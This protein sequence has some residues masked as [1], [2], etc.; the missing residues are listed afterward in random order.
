M[1]MTSFL[2]HCTYIKEFVFHSPFQSSIMELPAPFFIPKRSKLGPPPL[3]PCLRVLKCCAT[4]PQFNFEIFGAPTL[5]RLDITASYNHA[6]WLI[7]C[8]KKLPSRYPGLERLSIG[9]DVKRPVTGKRLLDHQPLYLAFKQSLAE[10]LH[11]PSSSQ[12]RC[13]KTE[14]P[15]NWQDV[16]TLAQLPHFET[17]HAAADFADFKQSPGDLPEGSFASLRHL[18]L[19]LWFLDEAVLRILENIRSPVLESLDFTVWVNRYA[20]DVPGRR[21]AYRLFQLASLE[22]FRDTLRRF[23]LHI[24]DND[25]L[26]RPEDEPPVIYDL[27]TIEILRHVRSL[28]RV[29]IVVPLFRYG[30]MN[31][32]GFRTLAQAWRRLRKLVIYSNCGHSEYTID[33]RTLW[34]FAF[35]PALEELGFNVISWDPDMH[36]DERLEPLKVDG[37][38]VPRSDSVKRLSVPRIVS[39]A[40]EGRAFIREHV[41][42]MFPNASVGGIRV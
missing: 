20:P 39:S 40:K 7:S 10:F 21:L 34:P 23:R 41:Q 17:L 35:S 37:K 33:V 8:L 15:I 25:T 9:T 36:P 1:D 6:G 5:R 19:K 31:L 29:S 4:R 22:R 12:F 32:R 24:V 13:L 30:R 18:Q 27:D 16:R 42:W 28:E 2:R 14:L 11:S 3:L 38:V 26:S